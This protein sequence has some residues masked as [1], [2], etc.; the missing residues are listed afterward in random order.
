MFKGSLLPKG[1]HLTR[2]LVEDRTILLFFSVGD[3][4]HFLRSLPHFLTFGRDFRQTE[5]L[6][7]KFGQCYCIKDPILYAVASGLCSRLHAEIEFTANCTQ[8]LHYLIE[9]N[10]NYSALQSSSLQRCNGRVRRPN[11]FNA[12][13]ATTLQSMQQGGPQSGRKGR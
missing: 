2:S 6:N 10:A 11:E 3:L 13:T 9:F 5:T 8:S 1:G 12:I 7:L 4:T